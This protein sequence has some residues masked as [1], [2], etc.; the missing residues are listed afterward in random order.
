VLDTEKLPGRSTKRRH[1]LDPDTFVVLYVFDANSSIERKNPEA[2]LR[3]F[4]G[5]FGPKDP[6]QLCIKVSNSGKLEHR[7]RLHT[8]FRE[9]VKLG[10][11][12]RIVTENQSRLETL[13]LISAVDCY[14][15]LHRSEGFGYTCAEAMGY[16]VPVIATRY[17]GN[18][19]Y[20]DDLTAYLVDAKEVE[21]QRAE[22]PFQRGSVWAEPDLDSAVH[23]LQTVFRNRDEAV[24]RG[25][26]GQELIRSRLSPAAIGRRVAALLG[27]TPHETPQSR[28]EARSRAVSY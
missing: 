13:N 23:A 17:S 18:L 16:G 27:V 6:V 25:V 14:M 7:Q 26:R 1:G 11:R 10:S 15:S 19:D 9:A 4:S 5:A 12:V 22:G 20:M 24:A 21:V 2:A 3:A 8:F 28:V